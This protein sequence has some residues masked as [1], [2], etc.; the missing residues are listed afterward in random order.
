VLKKLGKFAESIYPDKPEFNYKRQ[1]KNLFINQHKQRPDLIIACDVANYERLYWPHD[2]AN[3]PMI[4]ID[5]HISNSL[6]GQ[7]NFVSATSSSACEE[8]F[9]VLQQMDPS[10]VDEYVAECLLFG[11]LYDSQVFHIHPL[12]PRTLNIAADLM[13]LGA[14]LFDLEKELLSNKSHNIFVFWGKVLSSVKVTKSGN[15][16]W[17]CI[18]QQD[19][20]EN[21]LDLSSLIGFNNLLSQISDV[22]VTVLF[23]EKEDKKTKVSLRSKNT[24]VNEFARRFNGGGHTNAAGISSEKPIAQ[25]VK[26]IT[27][28]L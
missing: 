26:E 19:L 6:S 4:N 23:Y 22:D 7:F 10:L 27:E 13:R 1:P 9:V 8:L 20:L 24:D 17:A 14:N 16:A 5:H 3:I 18:T 21:N 12:Q 11:M 15:A 2:F 25:V 28:Q